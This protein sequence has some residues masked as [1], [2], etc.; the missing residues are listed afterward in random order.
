MKQR[1]AVKSRKG[2]T[3]V[4]LILALAITAIIGVSV[5]NIFWTAMK[6]DDKMRHVHDSYMEVL[7]AEQ[8]MT[9]D[10]ENA[11]TLDLSASYPDAVIFDGQPHEFSFL[12][13]TPK[14]IK[15]V[16]Y[17]GGLLS[18]EV[19]K[20]MIGRVTNP[21]E[22]NQSR[23]SLPVEFLVRQE[24]SLAD[25]L[26][27][28]KDNTTTQIVAAGLKKESF[29]CRYAPFV[30]DL[31]LSGAKAIDYHETWDEKGLPMAVS[32]SFV[33]YDAKHPQSSLLFKRDIF[34]ALSAGF[35]HE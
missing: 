29:Q 19:A 31:H 2:F 9:H 1:A 5:Y 28:T 14:G 20:S 16:H 25:W 11:I 34:L 17:Y 32:C 8:A 3:I 7:L 21:S 15:H 10:L 22:A 6:L 18:G 23:D 4:E 26:N 27:E 35:Y 30:K 24:S 33:L 12:T 13:Q